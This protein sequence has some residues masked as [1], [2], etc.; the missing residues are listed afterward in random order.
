MARYIVTI[1]LDSSSQDEQEIGRTIDAAIRF[2]SRVKRLLGAIVH[3]VEV[4]KIGRPSEMVKQLL[5][6]ADADTAA[7]IITQIPKD[8]M[9]GEG[10]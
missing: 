3:D 2:D 4:V 9:S 8:I 1:V 10:P 5:M 7:G 6:K